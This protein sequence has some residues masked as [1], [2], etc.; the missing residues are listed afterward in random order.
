MFELLEKSHNYFAYNYYSFELDWCVKDN[1]FYQ[2]CKF[3]GE[4]MILEL[5]A[6]F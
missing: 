3:Q 5:M 6:I 2:L 4:I 1:V